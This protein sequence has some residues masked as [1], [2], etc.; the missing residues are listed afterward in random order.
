MG[1]FQRSHFKKNLNSGLNSYIGH[2]RANNGLYTRNQLC[3]TSYAEEAQL[4][5][6]IFSKIGI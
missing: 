2:Y 6:Q 3:M 5:S 4:Y 1:F